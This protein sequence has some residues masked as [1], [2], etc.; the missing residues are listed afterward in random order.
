MEIY[1]VSIKI[2]VYIVKIKD[3][4]INIWAIFKVGRSSRTSCAVVNSR[5]GAKFSRVMEKQKLVISK[6]LTYT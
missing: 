5:F 6:A 2:I 3:D 1:F 4:I